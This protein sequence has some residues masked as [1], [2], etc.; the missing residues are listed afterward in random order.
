[1]KDS[2]GPSKYNI[3]HGDSFSFIEISFVSFLK[4]YWDYLLVTNFISGV[5][6]LNRKPSARLKYCPNIE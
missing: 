5:S 1:M 6:T 4:N 2:Q 3:Y